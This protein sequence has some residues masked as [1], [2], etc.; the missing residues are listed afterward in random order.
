MNKVS[1]A[2]GMSIAGNLKSS[3]IKELDVEAL[4]TALKA[5]VA[6]QPTDIT[7]QEAQVILNEYF[8]KLQAE[9]TQ[10]LKGEGEEFLKM[11]ATKEGVVTLPSGLQYKVLTQGE[12]KK[13][14]ATDS[15][16][17]HYEGI[18]INGEKFD[19]SYDRGEAAV[20]P[21]GGVIAG[22]VEALQLMNEGS[23][24]ELYI[25]Y[26]LAYGEQGAGNSIPPFSALIFT[27][28]LLEIQ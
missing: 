27:V 14:A 25:P 1:Y 19:S 16:K 11:N 9:Q 15:V 26:N 12:G 18:L 3:G 22:W 6:D 23:K 21:V 10:S 28:E 8:Q 24:W 5:M 2:L 13:P 4:C 20:F 7:I 17:C